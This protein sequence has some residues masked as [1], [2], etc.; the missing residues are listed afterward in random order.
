MCGAEGGKWDGIQSGKVYLG[1][2]NNCNSG[3]ATMASYMQVLAQEGKNSY[4]EEKEVGRVIVH[5]AFGFYWLSCSSSRKE[6][7]FFWWGSFGLPRW[8]SRKESAYLCKRCRFDPWVRKNPWR[9]KQ[10]PTPVFLPGKFHGPRS[11]APPL[12]MGHKRGRHKARKQ[13][14]LFL[15]GMRAPPTGALTLTGA[16]AAAA[17]SPQSCPTLC[18]PGCCL[19]IPPPAPALINIFLW[20]HCWSRLRFSDFTGFC[21][22]MPGRNFP[23]CRVS[24]CRESVQTEDLLRSHLTKDR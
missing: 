19:L 8:H 12:S 24:S 7:L 4:R 13:Q 22:L 16:A 6:S 3:L 1:L 18:D 11:L 20:K 21:P 10:Q 5:W 15:Q 23:G 9:K 17:K 14:T 2:A